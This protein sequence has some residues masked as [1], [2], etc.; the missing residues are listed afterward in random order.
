[1]AFD[2][3]LSYS[4]KDKTA[5]DAACSVLEA[6]GIRCWVAPRDIVPG[7]D[8]GE[9]II[10]AING[11]QVMV[12]IF[13][14]N[15]NA[16]QQVK[17]EV[18][19]AVNRG[20]PII[21]VR[22]ENVLPT[23]ALEY[24]LSTP[25][26]LDAFTPP[27]QQHLEHLAATV[28]HLL[29][30][31]DAP[32]RPPSSPAPA[33]SRGTALRSYIRPAAITAALL[34]ALLLLALIAMRE[35]TP[36]GPPVDP[37]PPAIA[38]SGDTTS[39]TSQPSKEGNQGEESAAS[40]PVNPQSPLAGRW[41]GEMPDS[42][43]QK[44]RGQIELQESDP[45]NAGSILTVSF[46]DTFPLPFCDATGQ[47][48]LAQNGIWNPGQGDRGAADGSFM[49]NFG[50]QSLTGS[51]VL[52]SGQT[53]VM[54]YAQTGELRWQRSA[55]RGPLSAAADVLPPQVEWPVQDVAALASRSLDYVRSRWQ[56][57]AALVSIELSPQ[58]AL[59]EVAE[60]NIVLHFFS[61]A[62]GLGLQFAPGAGPGSRLDENENGSAAR[63]LP[64]RF[65][66]LQEA[67]AQHS[68]SPQQ[69]ASAALEHKVYYDY[70]DIRGNNAVL[71]PCPYEKT[72]YYWIL[73][74]EKNW[75][76]VAAEKP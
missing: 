41:Q 8:W 16:S 7:A 22:I 28:K 4:S 10:E 43:G 42:E 49:L 11:C 3:F 51:Y 45:A 76:Y 74:T 24:F 36:A 67:M 35:P 68:L 12:L 26:W 13:S 32:A 30:Q 63:A 1:M 57:D 64:A 18:E 27:L 46:G 55:E 72:G 56:Q 14:G 23:Q 70:Q 40:A 9:A 69:L 48:Y 47:L 19:R 61:A 2:V 75:F 21:P 5:A 62:R 66:E 65:R 59:D 39:G 53:L 37:A 34:T 29:A 52:E 25:H 15:A 73:K 38:S 33:K 58:R 20:L 54:R 44:H 31:P 71:P 60:V 17:R 50:N 6:S